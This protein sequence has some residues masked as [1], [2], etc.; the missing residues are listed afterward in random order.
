MQPSEP[1]NQQQDETQSSD[2]SDSDGEW[3]DEVRDGWRNSRGEFF[4]DHG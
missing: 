4:P 1:A 3:Y 2:D